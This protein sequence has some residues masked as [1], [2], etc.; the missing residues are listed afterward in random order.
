VHL[1]KYL[2]QKLPNLKYLDMSENAFI[3][4]MEIQ[5]ILRH[6]GKIE[7][8]HVN[9]AVHVEELRAEFPGFE[10]IVTQ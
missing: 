6:I 10:K 5:A 3:T 4:L 1:Y 8:L 2:L 9:R 7:E